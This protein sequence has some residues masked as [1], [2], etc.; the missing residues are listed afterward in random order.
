MTGRTRTIATAALA[1]VLLTAGLTIMPAH[2]ATTIPVHDLAGEVAPGEY[3]GFRLTT[4]T[5]V[6]PAQITDVG[7]FTPTDRYA[8]QPNASGTFWIPQGEGAT[9][10]IRH[11]GEYTPRGEA[12]QWVN[13]RLTVTEHTQGCFN[14]T[15]YGTLLLWASNGSVNRFGFTIDLLDDA[16]APIEGIRGVTGF[17]DLDGPKNAG[18]PARPEGMELISGF[19]AAYVRADAHLVEY[20][21]NGWAGAVDANNENNDMT[22]PHAMQHYLGATFTGPHL[23]V[24]YT[25]NGGSYGCNFYPVDAASEWPLTYILNGGSGVIPNEQ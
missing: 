19:D 10:T 2:A 8:P 17:T 9:L 1:G 15:P 23:E 24:L 14:L 13:V 12:P 11:L 21:T 5:N 22:K 18:T 3:S 16:G 25:T 7:G 4:K 6:T 20:G